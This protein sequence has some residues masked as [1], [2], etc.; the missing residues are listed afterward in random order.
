MLAQPRLPAWLMALSL[1]L[2]TIAVYWPA[3]QCDFIQFDDPDFVTSNVH[4][5]NGLTW[6][7]I[8]WSCVNPVA[9]N[10]HP[11]TIWS[12]MVVF[13]VCGLR[14]WGHHLTN[15]ALHALNAG[16]VFTLLRW[17][18]GATWRSLLVAA[19]FALH[20]LRVESVAWVSER[21]DVL[22][23]F[24]GLLA[25]MAYARYAQGSTTGNQWSVSGGQLSGGPAL[26]HGPPVLRS[27]T[28]E[29]G[30]TA[31]RR[32]LITDHR[33]FFYCLSLCLFALGLMSKPML[34][35][36]PFVMLLL[37]YWPLRRFDLST[38]NSQL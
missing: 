31:R 15:V 19:L 21:K 12:H 11:L 3:T 16:L 28:A 35:T 27:R 13:Q 30:R 29:G 38:L 5:Q 6:E 2:G 23:G 4:V 7:N 17:I 22:S 1:V 9:D 34:V 14:P 18:T 24:F 8:K 37:D 36:W 10:W 32:L 26:G 25:L 20:P 33:P